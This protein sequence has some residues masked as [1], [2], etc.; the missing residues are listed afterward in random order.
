MTKGEPRPS[1]LAPLVR[2]LDPRTLFFGPIFQKDMRISGRKLGV[3]I[4]RS[5]FAL[6][7]A[8]VV[9]IAFYS[10]WQSTGF[11]QS[12]S[13]R[14]QSLQN[15]A[16]VIVV[17]VLW[18]QF[19]AMALLAPVLT[20]G[21][22]CEERRA[23]TLPTLLTTPLSP[24]QIV[25]SKGASRLA[26]LIIIALIALPVL[27]GVR[28]F[29]GVRAETILA[30]S[31]ISLTTAIMGASIGLWF[32]ARAARGTTATLAAYCMLALLM[33][34]LPMLASAINLI[35]E[36]EFPGA[37]LPDLLG[38]WA[39]DWPLRIPTDVLYASSPPL[40]LG[41]VSYGSAVGMP[42]RSIWVGASLWSLLISLGA[43]TFASVSLRAVMR[44]SLGAPKLTR[45]QRRQHKKAARAGDASPVDP[46]QLRARRSR[47]V[48]DRPVLWREIRQS[49][50][51]SKAMLV[52]AVLGVVLIMGIMYLAVDIDELA[53]AMIPIIIGTILILLQ[54]ALLSSGGFASEREARTLDALLT[55]RISPFQL[56]ASKMLGSIRRQWFIPLI[57]LIHM[58]VIVAYRETHPIVLLHLSIIFL[59]PI[60]M[61]SG[62]GVYFALRFRKSI[63]A[64]SVNLALALLLWLVWP[65][66]MG[67]FFGALDIGGYEFG[68]AMAN[69]T[70]FTHPVWLSA[71]SVEGARGHFSDGFDLSNLDY[72]TP[73]SN[74]GVVA[75]TILVFASTG[76]Q[77]FIG[78]LAALAALLRFE[79]HTGRAA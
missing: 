55:T 34:G 35:A 5:L 76:V 56:V 8:A 64:S 6:L 42:I 67:V 30:G 21:A 69:F 29:G 78:L 44:R 41:A 24:V 49:L 70:L 66:C 58:G 50:F 10:V 54:A 13:A 7:L 37:R 75:W 27:L 32:S 79:K 9:S 73:S 53:L 74:L 63:T 2:N 59:G 57:L 40:A 18:V 4:G 20:G 17:S 47:T 33:A 71:V 19:V 14:I 62:T 77:I 38:P 15:L 39:P 46:G 60:V 61:L 65:I 26:Q 23:Q 12:P 11:N 16:P 3:Y 51:P 36:S 45:R 1:R 28:L 31:S 68:E 22:I 52:A 43:L 72:D 25:C 48:A